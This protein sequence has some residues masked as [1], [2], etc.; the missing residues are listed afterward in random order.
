MD[1]KTQS[2]SLVKFSLYA[3]SIFVLIFLVLGLT[4]VVEWSKAISFMIMGIVMLIIV[5]ATLIRTIAKST[6]EELEI[7]NN[8]LTGSKGSHTL[9][10]TWNTLTFIFLILLGTF[11]FQT[12]S[13]LLRTVAEVFFFG[14]IIYWLIHN[15]NNNNTETRSIYKGILFVASIGFIFV[16]ALKLIVGNFDIPPGW[17]IGGIWIVMPLFV[18]IAWLV[19]RAN[20]RP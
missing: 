17:L 5:W 20:K 13:M 2:K 3:C 6:R 4:Q 15:K 10:S 18:L 9:F 19:S 12:H 1:P 16:I 14:G 11:S 7:Q 8:L